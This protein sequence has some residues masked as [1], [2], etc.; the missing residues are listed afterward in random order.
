MYKVYYNLKIIKKFKKFK[1]LIYKYINLKKLKNFG[2][3]WPPSPF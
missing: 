2:R 3:Q 1:I